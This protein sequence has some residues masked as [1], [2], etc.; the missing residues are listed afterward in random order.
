MPL[1]TSR[2]FPSSGSASKWPKAEGSVARTSASRVPAAQQRTASALSDSRSEL[3]G[4]SGQVRRMRTA[5]E[6]GLLG[7]T[8]WQTRRLQMLWSQ[9]LVT[10]LGHTCSRQGLR[11]GRSQRV[12]CSSTQAVRNRIGHGTSGALLHA[13][14]RTHYQQAGSKGAE[15]SSTC[16]T[17]SSSRQQAAPHSPEGPAAAL[18]MQPSSVHSSTPGSCSPPPAGDAAAASS[19][20][21]CTCHTS[22]LTPLL[23]LLPCCCCRCCWC[24]KTS[25]LDS[26]RR[27]HTATEPPALPLAARLGLLG[28]SASVCTWRATPWS[29]GQWRRQ[30]CVGSGAWQWCRTLRHATSTYDQRTGQVAHT[31]TACIQQHAAQHWC[32][33]YQAAPA[34]PAPPSYLHPAPHTPCGPTPGVTS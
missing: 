24:D 30:W 25:G 34:H 22:P 19:T 11:R 16:E 20:S 23:L 6:A 32:P 33:A 27:S 13:S 18:A 21:N 5:G 17:S 4:C 14:A 31:I 2:S 8:M 28:C 15:R 1:T 9:A 12:Q 7:C 10:A 26:K 3:Q 29:A